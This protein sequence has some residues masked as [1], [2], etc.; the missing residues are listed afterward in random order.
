MSAFKMVF[1][2]LVPT[3]KAF[4]HPNILSPCRPQPRVHTCNRSL[5]P[6]VRR[7]PRPGETVPWLWRRPHPF[8][9]HLSTA[10]GHQP[11]T[12]KSH[13]ANRSPPTQTP[14]LRNVVI[15]TALCVLL[16][17]LTR[18]PLPSMSTLFNNVSSQARG[19][20]P[21]RAAVILACLNFFTV[22]FC[23]PANMGLMIA[24]GAV[25]PLTH[26]FVALF[27]SKL[28][29]ACVA[30]SLGRTLLRSRAKRW[31]SDFP[32]LRNVLSRPEV[33]RW[34]FVV[35]LRLSP[36]PGFVLN[37]VLS[38]SNVSFAQYVLGTVVGI[39]PSVGNL[40]LVGD[41]AKGVG[42]GVVQ[43]SRLSA[44]LA[45]VLKLA[46]VTSFVLVMVHVTK[47][48]A[49]VF[50]E[51]VPSGSDDQSKVLENNASQ[52]SLQTAQTSNS[53]RNHACNESV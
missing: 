6:S 46:M 36:F 2:S 3:V 4:V 28:V 11:P 43:G 17:A 50:D 52:V 19:V 23:F 14:L 39:V 21:L 53:M 38:L 44:W 40:V 51:R 8:V 32:R 18:S 13:P 48:V 25:L 29:A 26:A 24:A 45:P 12:S 30:F 16:Y 33:S 49:A 37:Y 10:D 27:L 41:A 47:V 7:R 15:A 22:L 5:L 31:L 9:C 42:R 20:G 35:L 34:T 1:P